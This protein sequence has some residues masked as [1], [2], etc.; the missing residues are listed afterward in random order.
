MALPAESL[1]A[2]TLRKMKASMAEK[3][4]REDGRIRSGLLFTGNVHDSYPR[5]LLLDTRLSPLD[6]TAWMMI[7]LHALNNEGAVFP[8]YDELQLQLASPG[9]GKASRETVSRVLTMLRLT[10]WLSLCKRVR[11]EKGRVRGNIYALHDEPLTCCDAE[12]FDPR[13]LDMV[14]DTVSR[15][16][17]K[18]IRHTASEVLSDIK[19]EPGM[20]HYHSHI[21]L[22]ES[23]MG[24]AQTPGQLAAR[25][26]VNPMVNENTGRESGSDSVLPEKSVTYYSVRKPNN[27][28]RNITHSVI[29][30]TYVLPE[31]VKSQISAEDTDM[32]T[33]QL[34][35]LPEELAGSVLSSLLQM[36]SKNT[37]QNP[38]GWMLAVMKL[39]REGRFNTP[40]M[41][42][43]ES[44]SPARAPYQPVYN[45]D[46]RERRR[47]KVASPETVSNIVAEFRASLKRA[48]A[49]R[50]AAR[51]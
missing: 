9:R 21:T 38:V 24:A 1:I 12:K 35:A 51:V 5:R 29:K 41:S 17:N 32:L 4:S 46:E 28:V 14:L 42:V 6:K 30:N 25:Q 40:D 18:T 16:R 15:S 49:A 48:N 3:A 50:L 10:G 34:Q 11:D 43:H 31:S 27:Y 26:R 39:A 36:L 44:R 47:G 33:K 22:F 37:L 19:N 8:T 2:H 20:R 45:R 7:R 13:Y 23:R